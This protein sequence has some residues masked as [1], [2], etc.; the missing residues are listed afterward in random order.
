MFEGALD[1]LD[2]MWRLASPFLL[3]L[4]LVLIS[5]IPTN[6]PELSSIPPMLTLIAVYHWSLF[7][8]DLLPIGAIFVL[9][10]I[11]D[12]L[13]GGP[14]GIYTLM[15]LIVHGMVIS[16]RKFLFRKPFFITWIGFA[17]FGALAELAAWLLASLTDLVVLDFRNFLFQYLI[18]LGLFP[19][20]ALGLF[21]WERKIVGD[22]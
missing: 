2:R 8:P 7:R 20:L 13:G 6:I 4:L 14:M 19:P 3:G 18:T 11:Q 9:G 21:V 16:Q 1:Q 15:L 5:L 22:N 10:L 17:M 12:L